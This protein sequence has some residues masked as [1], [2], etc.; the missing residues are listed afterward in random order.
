MRV[1]LSTS[2]CRPSAS[3]SSRLPARRG[4]DA[5]RRARTA[6]SDAL[7][8]RSAGFPAAG[9]RAGRQRHARH[10]RAARRHPRARRR[11]RRDRGDADQA[12]RRQPLAGARAPGQ[13]AEGRRAHP[14]RRATRKRSLPARRARRRGRGERRSGRS[15][16]ALSPFAARRSTRRSSGSARPPLPPYIAARRP[17]ATADRADYQTMFAREDGAVAAPTAGLHFTPALVER[18]AARGVALHRV[19]LHVG[20]GTFLP[21]KADDTVDHA[22]HAEWGRDRRGDRRGAQRAAREGRPDRRVGT[23]SARVLESAA[24][25][26]GASILRRRDLDLHHAGL[27][28]PRGRRADDQFPSAALD[29]VH[30]GQRLQRPCDDAG[31]LRAC[32]RGGLSLL[33]LRRRLP[34]GARRSARP[35]SAAEGAARSSQFTR[36]AKS[37]KGIGLAKR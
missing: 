17:P 16:A 8:R 2:I 7:R 27:P 32:D 30:A 31:G 29:A 14:L 3:R 28:L 6:R 15:H 35:L 9:R 5:G 23:T 19:T 13:E 33:L 36:R 25:E 11:G 37:A 4:A 26:D 18:I 22:M 12:A 24:G 34:A 10:R 1:D 21:V 20:A